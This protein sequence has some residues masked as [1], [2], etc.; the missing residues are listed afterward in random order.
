MAG[1]GTI[2]RQLESAHTLQSVITTMKTLSAARITQY[3]RSVAALESSTKTLE[4]AVQAV[5]MQNP[6]LADI[7]TEPRN[8]RLAVIVLGSDR[9]LCGPFNERIA[10]HTAGMLA[11]RAPAEKVTVLTVGRRLES[12]LAGTGYESAASVR[13]PGNVGAFDASVIE[14]LTHVDRWLADGLAGRL[15]LAYNRPTKGAAYESLAVKV[16]PV[17]RRWLAR[18]RT[19]KWPTSRLPMPLGDD[20]ALLQGL[21]RQ[22][23][24]HSLVLAFAASLAS[25]NAARLASMDAAERNIDERLTQLRNAYRQARQNAVTAELLDIQSAYAATDATTPA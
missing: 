9:G 23:L 10:R 6:Q 2:R 19:R 18:L 8:S 20:T 1:T 3:R 22:F 12:R 11:A 21:V 24:A 13:P 16:L 15:Y 4:L 7:V 5:L 14:T 17:D 25:E